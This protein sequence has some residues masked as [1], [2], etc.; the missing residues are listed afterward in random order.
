MRHLAPLCLSLL[1]W[2]IAPLAQ[3]QSTDAQ[4]V[5]DAQIKAFRSGS[6]EQAFSHAAPTLRR[7]FG[8]TDNFIAMVKRGYM[9]IYGA[10][11]WR[12]GRT[13]E[14][15]GRTFQEV[16]LTGPDGRSWVALYT[17]IQGS[18]GV[19]KI[20]GVRIVPGNDLAT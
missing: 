8:G 6:H 16:L 13:K 10:R 7:M 2:S 20:A 14:Q 15:G 9:P 19:W 3:A 5:I 17:M 12:F 11:N 1:L 4:G 18:D